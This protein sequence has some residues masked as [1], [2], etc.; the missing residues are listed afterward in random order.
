MEMVLVMHMFVIM[1][2]IL[3]RMLML[4]MLGKVEPYS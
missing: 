3:V 2:H 4:M 1:C